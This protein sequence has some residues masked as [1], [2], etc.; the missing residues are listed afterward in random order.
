MS[1]APFSESRA[2]TNSS[3]LASTRPLARFSLHL[4]R[5]EISWLAPPIKRGFVLH[6]FVMQDQDC[7]TIYCGTAVRTDSNWYADQARTSDLL[8]RCDRSGSN[9]GRPDRLCR[10]GHTRRWAAP[11]NVIPFT[12]PESHEVE[13]YGDICR[14]RARRLSRSARWPR[15]RCARSSTK[16][17]DRQPPQPPPTNGG[18]AAGWSSAPFPGSD[19]NPRL[20]MDLENLGETLATLHDPPLHPARPLV[21][22]QGAGCELNKTSVGNAR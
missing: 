7:S 9:A 12:D 5:D 19:E 2:A 11:N 6:D 13:V 22:C 3:Q 21:A 20:A 17:L 8:G 10:I 16:R 18:C 14:L 1:T 15:A 4:S